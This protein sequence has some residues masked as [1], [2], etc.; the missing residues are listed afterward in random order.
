MDIK[1]MDFSRYD[2]PERARMIY[3][4]YIDKDTSKDI[5]F[6]AECLVGEIGTAEDLDIGLD[7][8]TTG[9]ESVHFC[10]SR[11]GTW[12]LGVDG[13]RENA[14]RVLEQAG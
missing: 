6:Q 4:A 12:D 2:D 8:L 3:S 13:W 14:V 7:R 10:G 9:H 5:R 1:D 11:F